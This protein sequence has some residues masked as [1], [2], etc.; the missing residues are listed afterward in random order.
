MRPGNFR[1]SHDQRRRSSLAVPHDHVLLGN[2]LKLGDNNNRRRSSSFN[3]AESSLVEELQALRR[4]SSSSR[5]V[6][7][8][9]T[10]STTPVVPDQ[11]PLRRQDTGLEVKTSSVVWTGIIVL[12]V[13]VAVFAFSIFMRSYT[14]FG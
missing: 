2:N 7:T 5:P 4:N 13:I 9:T 8:T 6:S 10:P 11:R 12:A 1:T 3:A 14:A